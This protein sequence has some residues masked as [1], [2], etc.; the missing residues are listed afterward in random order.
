MSELFD[1]LRAHSRTIWRRL[2]GYRSRRAV[3][4]PNKLG[5]VNTHPAL[6]CQGRSCAIHNPSNHSMRSW[7]VTWRSD[8]GILERTCTHGCGHPDPDQIEYWR[9]TGQEYQAV[10]GCCGCCRT[11]TA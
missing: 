8:R 6:A 10:H 7:P 2:H 5:I 9:E 1:W 4:D 11:K 3:T